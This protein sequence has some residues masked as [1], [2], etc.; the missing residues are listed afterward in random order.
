[1]IGKISGRPF[2]DHFARRTTPR[3]GPSDESESAQK[4]NYADPLA[5]YG[6]GKAHRTTTV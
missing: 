1:M 4:L 2:M 3:R 5:A 6:R